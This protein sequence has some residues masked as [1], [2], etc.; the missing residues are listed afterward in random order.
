MENLT[1]SNK[2]SDY[3]TQ[4]ENCNSFAGIDNVNPTEVQ[5]VGE[6][7]SN[8]NNLMSVFKSVN[9][10]AFILIMQDK[11]CK[12]LNSVTNWEPMKGI[13]E[14]KGKDIVFTGSFIIASS[15]KGFQIAPVQ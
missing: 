3:Q 8:S 9:T 2:I 7:L 14:K 11:L 10:E 13:I 15:K 5:Y 1:I 6:K 12:Y 4:A